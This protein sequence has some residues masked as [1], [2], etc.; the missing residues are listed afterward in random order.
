MPLVFF[1]GT[2][3]GLVRYSARAGPGLYR[4]VGLRGRVPVEVQSAGP[5]LAAPAEGQPNM[6]LSGDVLAAPASALC[7]L[8]RCNTLSLSLTHD[9]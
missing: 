5:G 8:E 7:V 2:G 4:G 1:G 6:T 9:A 3:S